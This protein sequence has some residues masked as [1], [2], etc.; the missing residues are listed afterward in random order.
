MLQEE[1]VGVTT[2]PVTQVAVVAVKRESK[3]DEY[4]RIVEIM[5]QFNGCDVLDRYFD[6]QKQKISKNQK[7]EYYDGNEQD[8]MDLLKLVKLVCVNEDEQF[9]R[10]FSIKHFGDSK[11]VEQLSTK[12]QA[13]L[14]Q[15]GDYQEK[16][17]VLE[18]CGI[19]KTPTYVCIKGNG[20]ITLGGQIINLSQLKG[21]IALS[22]SS[23][24]ELGNV[25]VLGTRIVTV[26]NLTSF[27]DYNELD[28][29]VIYLGGFHNTTKR[30]FLTDFD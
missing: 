12:T 22:T 10:D 11:R 20:R 27:H 13:L 17:S 15:Y 1:T 29:F 28:D 23:L 7:V 8:F 19:V 16:D 9:I 25:E 21:D 24:K 4:G 3:K 2:N 30:Q 18:E 5:G 6:A 14:Y 26:E